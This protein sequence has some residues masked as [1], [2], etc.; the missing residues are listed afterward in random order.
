M[1]QTKGTRALLTLAGA[2]LAVTAACGNGSTGATQ[3]PSAPASAPVSPSSSASTT[4]TTTSTTSVAVAAP[5]P[6]PGNGG[7]CKA[8][9]VGLSLGRADGAAG[10]VYRP[11]IITNSSGHTCTIQGFPGVSYVAG[12]DGHQVGPAADRDGPKGSAYKLSKGDSVFADIG[13]VQ[14][15]NYDSSVCK[16]TSVTGLRVYLPQDTASKFVP[17]PGTG[18]AGDIPGDQLTVKSVQKGT[19]G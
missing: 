4:T 14:V 6:A 18:C 8:D 19:G 17:N 15:M 3:P 10:T 5:A 1:G 12:A 7:D 16:P 9:D 2:A 13:F 11:L